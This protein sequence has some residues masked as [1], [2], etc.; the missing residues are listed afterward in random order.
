MPRLRG[1]VIRSP[2]RSST[3][4]RPRRRRR[5]LTLIEASVATILG[6]LLLLSVN[7]SLNMLNRTAL[8]Q[9]EA[10]ALS[11]AAD[12]AL[13]AASRDLQD[14]L[15]ASGRLITRARAVPASGSG[16]IGDLPSTLMNGPT[17]QTPL[18]LD[19]QFATYAPDDTTLLVL[20]W[21]T[22]TLSGIRGITIPRVRPGPGIRRVGRAGGLTGDNTCPVTAWCGLG[23]D[24]TDAGDFATAAGAVTP[25]PITVPPAGALV[26]MR[27]LS[28]D[29]IN[30]HLLWRHANA[31][32]GLSEMDTI[33]QVAG[34]LVNVSALTAPRAVAG[35]GTL[36]LT[37]D[38]TIAPDATQPVG[39]EVAG[40]LGIG[41]N[42]TAPAAAVTD[43]GGD[44]GGP[45]GNAA[46]HGFGTIRVEG[47]TATLDHLQVATA[48][49]SPVPGPLE[50]GDA[51][52]TGS[53]NLAI[54]G[55]TAARW[56][57]RER[58][59]SAGLTERV[60]RVAVQGDLSTPHATNPAG[61]EADHAGVI[62]GCAGTR[63][64]GGLCVGTGGRIAI[65]GDAT[66]VQMGT[67]SITVTGDIEMHGWMN[68]NSC[69]GC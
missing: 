49:A 4:R 36:T 10:R 6:A 5:G 46:Q 34:S 61:L 14:S 12:H 55:N 48:D 19:L 67:P 41:G 32:L 68:V 22:E 54:T 63:N 33:M 25:T 29:R 69:T 23:I 65:A 50:I 3:A 15:T 45:N 51:P 20:V 57:F 53:Q 17:A 24:W 43:A 37:G 66:T 31:P 18:G 62:K 16:G 47:T 13:R 28:L 56:R 58:M 59:T 8:I 38:L 1:P 40:T 52:T 27:D 11:T 44:F 42:L 30:T 39:L 21:T 7:Q 26:A 9:T 35:I 2:R 64:A 60:G